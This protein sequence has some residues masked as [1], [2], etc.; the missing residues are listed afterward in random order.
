MPEKSSK[1]YDKVDDLLS[2]GEIDDSTSLKIRQSIERAFS[3]SD[4]VRR[5]IAKESK[6]RERS[7]KQKRKS[8]G[9]RKKGGLGKKKKK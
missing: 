1:A 4:R 9:Q 3:N 8:P 7:K 2:K 6:G 5:L